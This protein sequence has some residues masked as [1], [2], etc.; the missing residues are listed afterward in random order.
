MENIEEDNKGL[1]HKTVITWNEEKKRFLCSLGNRTIEIV[2]SS[3]FKTHDDMV[4]PEEL[5]VDSI[6]GFIK[7][8]F[9][10]YA[11]RD[12]LDILNYESEGRGIVEKVGDKFMFTEIIIRAH[13]IVAANSQI[14]KA[15]ELI[16][17]ASK[18]CFISNFITAKITVTPE[19]KV[20]L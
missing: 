17:I 7:N 2:A 8:T 15:K 19:I 12:N 11:K 10:N 14:E 20:E 3:E 13:V 16:E 1:T 4:T 9:M 6:E 18:N 5:F